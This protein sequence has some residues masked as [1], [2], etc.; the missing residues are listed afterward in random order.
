MNPEYV[1]QGRYDRR[2]GW[3]DL[4]TETTRAEAVQ[5]LKEYEENEPMYLHRIVRRWAK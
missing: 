5:R 1:V 2:H 3:E 4:V